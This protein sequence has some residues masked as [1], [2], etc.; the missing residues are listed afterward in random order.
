MG[1]YTALFQSTKI[2]RGVVWYQSLMVIVKSHAVMS[3]TP[4]PFVTSHPP[5][6]FFQEA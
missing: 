4:V 5:P 3:P 1:R 2:P 6:H